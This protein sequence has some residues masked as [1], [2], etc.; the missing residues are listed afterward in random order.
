M[1]PEDVLQETYAR[2][3]KSIAGFR[4]KDLPE[5]FGWL[6][7]IAEHVIVDLIGRHKSKDII[8]VEE[9]R[10][11]PH[12]EPSPSKGLRREERLTRLQ[13]ALDGLSPEQ[14]EIIIL[15]RIQG[16]KIKDAAGKMNR[17]PNAAMK[18]LTRAL[19]KLK[20][21]FGDTESLHLPQ[22]GLVAEDR[23]DHDS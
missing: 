17:T 19:K 9:T 7:R 12:P 23:R 14:R 18:L 22:R 3:W 20:E 5:L 16:L 21:T 8:Y 2:A 6:R 10:D 15:V 11:S 13:E 4:G 1:D